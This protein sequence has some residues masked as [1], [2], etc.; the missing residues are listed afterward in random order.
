[1]VAASP[2]PACR[3]PARSCS[4]GRSTAATCTHGTTRARWHT[5]HKRI[6]APPR[7]TPPHPTPPRAPCKTHKKALQKAHHQLR[8][9]PQGGTTQRVGQQR[10]SPSCYMHTPHPTNTTTTHEL[11]HSTLHTTHRHTDTQRAPTGY[12]SV[13]SVPATRSVAD[14]YPGSGP[15]AGSPSDA[16]ASFISCTRLAW[17]HDVN[18]RQAAR[19]RSR[20]QRARSCTS[21]R[22]Q[23]T[24]LHQPDPG[25][26]L[27]NQLPHR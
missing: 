5:L 1:V 27:H 3:T 25:K 6:N 12:S 23:H 14:T 16:A 17:T 19:P 18:T 11:T 7:P 20:P 9:L 10:Q 15:L 24:H 21:T 4:A 22:R 13:Y 2:T 26:G 8:R